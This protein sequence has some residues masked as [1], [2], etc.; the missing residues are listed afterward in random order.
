M[1]TFEELLQWPA[2]SAD[3]MRAKLATGEVAWVVISGKMCS[4]KEL[5]AGNLILPGTKEFISYGNILR[6]NLDFVLDEV[7]P[8]YQNGESLAE[9]ARVVKRI[10]DYN[11]V[12][13]LS[14][15]LKL[16]SLLRSGE[17]FTPWSRSN[18]MRD[19]LQHMGS[20]YLPD[21]NYLPNL[22]AAR[23]KILI[24]NGCSIVAPGSRFLQDVEIPR[25][26]GAFTVRLDVTRETQLRRLK[27]RDGLEPS[28]ELMKALE[29]PG[30]TELDDYP[31]DIR[32]NNDY[33]ETPEGPVLLMA[34]VQKK[35]DEFLAGRMK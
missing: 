30:E 20:D 15:V 18:A 9:Q 3:L 24:E 27:A 1:S 21:A 32:V 10:L 11:D 33:E 17:E 2:G 28:E 26:V 19:I 22:A 4:G 5:V 8:L 23:A 14:L 34:E 6:E 31:H 12:N 16:I 29:H 7:V 25:S 35:V 13:S